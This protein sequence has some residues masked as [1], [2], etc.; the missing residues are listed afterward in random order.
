MDKL[1]PSDVLRD[2]DVSFCLC[3]GYVNWGA[4]RCERA[5]VDG[6]LEEHNGGM[7]VFE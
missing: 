4:R 3:S 2:M 1:R 5:V 6:K 7:D